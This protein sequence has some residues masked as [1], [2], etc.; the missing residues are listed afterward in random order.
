[1]VLNAKSMYICVK[2]I[3]LTIDEGSLVVLQYFA[4]ILKCRKARNVHVDQ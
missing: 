2:R 4:S 1:M 3:L